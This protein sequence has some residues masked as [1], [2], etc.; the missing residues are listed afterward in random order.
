M[1]KNLQTIAYDALLTNKV[2]F[3]EE[4][5]SYHCFDSGDVTENFDGMGSLQVDSYRCSSLFVSKSYQ[6][7][8][9]TLQ[10]ML[11]AW[12]LSEQDDKDFQRTQLRKIFNQSQFEMIWIFYAGLTKFQLVSFQELLSIRN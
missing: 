9:Q 5:I 7:I 2:T 1:L 10:E 3:T 8:H 4:E 11:V 12:Y 6:F